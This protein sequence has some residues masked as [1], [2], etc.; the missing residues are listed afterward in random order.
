MVSSLTYQLWGAFTKSA[1]PLLGAAG[2]IYSLL[3]MIVVQNPDLQLS[4]DFL[5]DFEVNA[6]LVFGALLA[7]DV[8][9]MLLGWKS[10]GH[11]AH[12]GGA[13]FGAFNAIWGHVCTLLLCGMVL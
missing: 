3:A 8:A 12:L 11:A 10:F 1:S 5:P 9:G 6:A 4:V 13:A 2:A 7:Y